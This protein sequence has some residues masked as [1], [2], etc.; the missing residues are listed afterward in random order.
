MDEEIKEVEV[1]ETEAVEETA[2]EA[3]Q[4]A[5][6]TERVGNIKISVDVV[7]TIAGVATMGCDGVYAMAGTFA[8]DIAERF[9]A[10]K[11]NA[12]KGVKVDMSETNA[13]VDLYIIAKYG[14]RIPE[15][16][17]E[18]QEAVKNSIESM[19]GMTVDKVNIHIEGVSF[20]EEEPEI[21]EEPKADEPEE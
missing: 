15:L 16:A 7:A 4:E 9:G 8:G 11:K 20:E 5:Q 14:V 1:V 3:E 13:S 6:N 21:E 10:K 18:V 2:P 19:T 12:N 17:W